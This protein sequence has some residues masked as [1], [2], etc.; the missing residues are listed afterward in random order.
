MFPSKN[1]PFAYEI[2]SRFRASLKHFLMSILTANDVQLLS[3][4]IVFNTKLCVLR[5]FEFF[6]DIILERWRVNFS[7]AIG[8]FVSPS[9]KASISFWKMHWMLLN[10]LLLGK[11][12]VHLFHVCSSSLPCIYEY[13][14]ECLT[15]L[16]CSRSWKVG[17]Q[18]AM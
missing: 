3:R 12:S 15:K 4:N 10:I 17:F 8:M 13:N 1:T 5:T 16:K 14:E 6:S 2:I 9:F 18:S 11:R 7:T